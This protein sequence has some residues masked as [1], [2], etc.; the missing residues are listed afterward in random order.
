M[1][2]A[3]SFADK[4]ARPSPAPA[5]APAPKMN[6]AQTASKGVA[7]AVRP[8]KR[9]DGNWFTQIPE[10]AE[11]LLIKNI[12]IELAKQNDCEYIAI[13]SGIH[14]TKTARDPRTGQ[15]SYPPAP[16]HFTVEFQ[17]RGINK[18]MAAHVYTETERIKIGGIWQKYTPYTYGVSKSGKPELKIEGITENPQIFKEVRPGRKGDP[19]AENGFRVWY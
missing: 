16:Y 1:V 13:R 12:S 14:N 15:V 7:N 2:N 10:P 11:S 19:D 17:R 9:I 8:R 4:P 3:I 6:W 5:P 18:W